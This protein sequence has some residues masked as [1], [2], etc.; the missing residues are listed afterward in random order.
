V[1]GGV[2]VH[3]DRFLTGER[4]GRSSSATQRRAPGPGRR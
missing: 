3:G 2:M 1:D 4:P